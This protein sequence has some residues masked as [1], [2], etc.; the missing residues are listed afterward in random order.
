MSGTW[1]HTESVALGR[2]SDA[3]PP[4]PG[5]A[6]GGGARCDII[7]SLGISAMVA[8]IGENGQPS[9]ALAG[10]LTGEGMLYLRI[11]ECDQGLFDNAGSVTIRVQLVR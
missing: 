1:R 11:N 4:R 10:D 5:R 7:G 6:A 9:D 3:P 2:P 8:R